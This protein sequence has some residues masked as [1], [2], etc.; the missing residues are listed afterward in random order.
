MAKQKK[1]TS[2]QVFDVCI[3][4]LNN[5]GAGIGLRGRHQIVVPK[6]LPGESVRVE[7]DP[8]RDRKQRIR[9]LEVLKPVEERKEAP[10]SYFDECG[11][12]HLQH[13]SY[14]QQLEYKHRQVL[15]MAAEYPGLGHLTIHQPQGMPEPY[16]YRN[17]TQLPYKSVEEDAIFGLYRTGSHD[18][19]AIDQCIVENQDANIILK[20]V[21]DWVRRYKISLYN[22]AADQGLLRHVMIRKSIFTNEVMVALVVTDENVPHWQELLSALKSHV[23][24]LRSFQ[25]NLNRGR[26]NVI[27]GQKNVVV[28]GEAYIHEQLGTCRFRIYPQTFFQVN[29]VQSVK[30]LQQLKQIAGLRHDD[31]IVDLYCGVGAVGLFLADQVRLLTGIEIN[32]ESV[33]AAQENAVDNGLANVEFRCG[34]A[35]TIFNDIESAGEAV[36]GII[37]DPPRKGLPKELIA[38][39]AGLSPRW[40]AY[41]SCN[42]ATLMRDLNLFAK[43]GYA[44]DEVFLYDMFPQTYHVECLTVID[45]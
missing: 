41:I 25:F 37:V 16:Y 14:E 29:S 39:I 8:S 22:E 13:V 15:K 28:W 19:L 27:V 2:P 9:L 45:R 44:G 30:L 34:D 7:Y 17:K 3:E 26:T 12:C 1:N 33:R 38:A 24:G 32:A 20:L 5:K 18:I 11:G 31:H 6:T 43:L 42:P 35:L 21:A 36:D 40:V 10:C 4:S 23:A